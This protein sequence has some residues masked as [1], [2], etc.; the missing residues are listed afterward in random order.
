M[1]TRFFYGDWHR[2]LIF[3]EDLREFVRSNLKLTDRLLINGEIFY[4]KI[5]LEGGRAAKQGNILAKRIEKLDSFERFMKDDE[6]DPQNA[7]A[8]VE[9]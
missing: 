6:K 4:H 5:D 3:D 1:D 9:Q 7:Q 2:V 8:T